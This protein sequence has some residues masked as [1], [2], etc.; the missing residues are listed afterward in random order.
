MKKNNNTRRGYTQIENV[1][2]CPPCGE[3]P[4]APEG[5]CPG[6][7]LATKR[8]ATKKSPILPRLTAVLPQSGKTNFLWHYVPFPPRRGEDNEAMTSLPQ[9]II[10]RGFTL[11]ELLVVVLIIGILAAVALP[12]YQKAVAKARLSEAVLL[13]QELQKAVDIHVLQH[14]IQDIDFIANPELLDIDLSTS[15]D[16]LCGNSDKTFNCFI[17]CEVGSEP[18]CS[19]ALLDYE[20]EIPVSLMLERSA[21]GIWNKGCTYNPNGNKKALSE[22]LCNSLQTQGWN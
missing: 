19:I 1:V 17:F 14:G 21:D 15:I 13:T 8:G 11:I 22:Y 4:L 2:I 10:S 5:F 6:G 9:G 12:Q 7:A 20:K 16:K 3:K 18:F